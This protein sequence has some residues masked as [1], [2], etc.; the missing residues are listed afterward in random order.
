MSR[1]K[2]STK[3]KAR[4]KK[5]L[6]RA[7]GF[8]GG[9][10]KLFRTAVERVNRALQFAYRDRRV[11]K[12]DFRAL[13]IS[14]IGAATRVHGLSYSKFIDGLKKANVALD[15]KVLSDLAIKSPDTFAKIVEVAKSKLA[16]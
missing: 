16:A 8:R 1:V 14:R 12:R 2:R 6:K 9:Q 3:A 11:K 10:S 7:K 13:W 4:R 15:R 5:V